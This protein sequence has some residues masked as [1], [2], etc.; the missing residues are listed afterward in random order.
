[1]K[2]GRATLLGALENVIWPILILVYL[3]F[4]VLKPDAMFNW[5]MIRDIAYSSIPLGFIVLAEAL[6]LLNGSFDLSVG[7][8]AGLTAA[9]GAVIATKGF[10]PAPLSPFVPI[11]VGL[12]CGCF[13][14]FLV[15]KMGLN[16]F[17][18][19]LGTFLAFDGLQ[20]LVRHTVIF[21][22]PAIYLIPGGTWFVSIGIFVLTLL[23]LH[24]VLYRTKFGCHY[25]A[26]GSTPGAAAMLGLSI[27]LFKFY[28]FALS[29]TLSGAA[30]LFYTGYTGAYGPLIAEDTVFMAFASAVLGGISLTGGRGKIGNVFG[31]VILLGTISSGL[32]VLAVSP[33]VRRVLFGSLVVVAIII[34]SLRTRVRE[35]VMKGV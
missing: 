8:I 7:Q 15:G 10:V 9:I 34:D 20:L 35:S 3:I 5:R 22:F 25:L 16:A 11:G 13:N 4:I 30:G 27:P 19:T 28:S 23:I 18:A 12:L 14:G 31:G 1:M 32:T 29:G 26:V 6:V 2:I 17:L 21:E 24:F 33:Y